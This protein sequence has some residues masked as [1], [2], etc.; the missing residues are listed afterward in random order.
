M[1]VVKLK[2]D[3]LSVRRKANCEL[4][5]SHTRDIN[6]QPATWS[7]RNKKILFLWIK[8]KILLGQSLYHPELTLSLLLFNTLCSEFPGN[9]LTCQENIIVGQKSNE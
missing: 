4:A 8:T 7:A 2:I 1:N 6:C 9:L 5:L 3:S